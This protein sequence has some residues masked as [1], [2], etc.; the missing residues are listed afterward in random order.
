MPHSKPVLTSL[1]VVLEAAQR[2]DLALVDDDVVAEQP[3]LG[4]AGAGDAAF[5][6]HAAGNRAELRA[7]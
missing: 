1:D 3:G 7:P 6:H 5:G 4:V 2:A